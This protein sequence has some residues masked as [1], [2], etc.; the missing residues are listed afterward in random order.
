MNKRGVS[1]VIATIILIV[2]VLIAVGIV[3]AVI[4]NIISKQT[5]GI[6]LG[7]LTLD[8]DIKGVGI[9]ET[10]NTISV[11]VK[12]KPGQGDLAGFKFVFKNETD[13][14]VKEENA[15]LNEL[16]EKRFT[17]TL[18]M[19]VSEVITITLIPLIKSG[20]K[21]LLGN[22]VDVY[23]VKTGRSIEPPS[24]AVCGDDF[25]EGTE[26]C[27]GS[28]LVG[29]NCTSQGY[30]SGTLDCLPDCSGYDTLHFTSG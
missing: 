22:V 3:W 11:L 20:D 2:L 14:E 7:K 6:S 24:G 15:T 4:S 9:N 23:D 16:E 1:T 17:F 18:S 29:E 12:R 26:T 5:E 25:A 27:D 13:T 8:A 21:K 19:N 30:D 10:T 28:D